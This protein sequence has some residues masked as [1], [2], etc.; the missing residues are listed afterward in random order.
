MFCQ[1][2]PLQ[3]S[4]VGDRW[5]AGAR[6]HQ[7]LQGLIQPQDRHSLPLPHHNH[8]HNPHPNPKAASGEA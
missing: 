7:H 1:W 5:A 4:V 3:G 2:M 6:D 8:L